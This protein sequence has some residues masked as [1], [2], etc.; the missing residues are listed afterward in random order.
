MARCKCVYILYSNKA[1][2]LMIE[3]CKVKYLLYIKIYRYKYKHSPKFAV[4]L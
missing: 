4:L 2:N 3:L 1:G